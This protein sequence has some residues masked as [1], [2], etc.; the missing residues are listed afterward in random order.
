MTGWHRFLRFNAIGVLGTSV[1][2][3]TLWILSA[4]S[5]LPLALATI[6]AVSAAIVHNFIWH[7]RW[8]W[9]DRPVTRPELPCAF[10]RFVAAN[11]LISYVGNVAV[12]TVVATTAGVPAV[13]ANLV[14]IAVCG[15]L[16]YW[17]ADR[18]V[19]AVIRSGAR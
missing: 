18:A 14:A 3:T 4:G 17:V 9:R 7:L 12:T 11:G 8:T 19:F 5:H 15:L 16:N 2:L 6:V 10:A 1:Q 13:A